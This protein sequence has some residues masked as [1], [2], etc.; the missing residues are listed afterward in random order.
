MAK[1][2]KRAL[3]LVLVIVMVL[4]L[5]ITAFAIDDANK[6]I[7]LSPETT[8][9]YVGGASATL[10]AVVSGYTSGDRI[11]WSSDNTAALSLGSSY[12][13]VNNQGIA[14]CY[15]TPR[16]GI[17]ADTTVTVTAQLNNGKV[18]KATVVVKPDRVSGMAIMQNNT[19]VSG[20]TIDL[21]KGS[22]TQFS[23]AAV[24]ANGSAVTNPGVKW[25]SSSANIANVSGSGYVTGIAPGKTSIQ[26]TSTDG[27]GIYAT[28]IINVVDR[29]ANAA[30][31]ISFPSTDAVFYVMKSTYN[32]SV[33]LTV[34]AASSG[35]ISYQWYQKS[36]TGGVDTPI[37]GARSAT[38]TPSV[39]AVGDTSYYCVV[40]N[41]TATTAS[42]LFTVSVKEPYEV[43][44]TGS[45]SVSIGS[46]VNVTANVY[47][48]TVANYKLTRENITAGQI[49]WTVS[50]TNALSF[51]ANTDTAS[52]TS[53]LNGNTVSVMV[54]GKGATTAAYVSA[55]YSLN[56]STYSTNLP[57]E[58]K[59]TTADVSAVVPMGGKELGMADTNSYTPFSLQSQ[60]ADAAPNID[61]IVFNTAKASSTAACGSFSAKDGNKY[62]ITSGWLSGNHKLSDVKFTS[63]ST[64]G[65][66]TVPYTAYG[67]SGDALCTGNMTI[68][69]YDTSTSTISVFY[70][71][72]INGSIGFSQGD[73][74]AW[75]KAQAGD[76][77]SLTSVKLTTLPGA[78]ELN[79][80][81]TAVDTSTLYYT[82]EQASNL[83]KLINNI[84]YKAPAN[85]GCYPVAFTCTG[86]QSAASPQLSKTGT[87][88]LCVTK[89]TVSDITYGVNSKL[90]QALN[91]VDFSSV[92]TAA[93]G[94]G[95]ASPQL[96]VRFITTPAM[97]ALYRGG[98]TTEANKV[99]AGDYSYYVNRSD[100]SIYNIGNMS[101]VT[102]DKD[103]DKGIDYV[104]YGVYDLSGTLIYVGKVKFDYSTAVGCVDSYPEGHTFTKADFPEITASDPIATLRFA[105]PAS[106]GSL[107]RD[108]KNGTGTLVETTDE[109]Y[110]TTAVKDAYPLT[111]LTFI[112]D[113]GNTENVVF[114]YTAVTNGNK[115]IN[116]SITM[117]AKTRAKSANFT[118]VTAAW[119]IGSVDY[120][121]NWGLVSGTDAVKKTFTPNGT[122]S[123][124]MMVAIL[125]RM[126]GS[127]AYENYS[128]SFTDIDGQGSSWY[129]DAV[130][131][132]YHNGYI[133][134]TGKTTF[135][136]N[137]SITR[138]EIASILWR[139]AGSPEASTSLSGYK[140]A[141]SIASYADTA[142]QWAVANNLI[143]GDNGYLRPAT[144]ASRAQVAAIIHRY[145]A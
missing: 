101:Y 102:S 48:N 59:Y 129:K 106:G 49:S 76:N 5:G 118:D 82:K 12:S 60:L 50:D 2:I 126:A 83:Q 103:K 128:H 56:N 110:T 29:V 63:S 17:T 41:G 84:K 122:M 86:K 104:N 136:P 22:S 131:W 46:G 40:S 61:Y 4:S 26:A 45:D 137:A 111:S 81:V 31:V 99:T 52:I 18:A 69:V 70:N 47:K 32:A 11:T 28:V 138:Q 1:N 117:L 119:A 24:H 57:I 3:S 105:Q 124:A 36:T 143:A 71:T 55:S 115:T 20:L 19:D 94:D 34:Q 10:T 53:T 64:P 23:A 123:R 130:V 91:D 88:F 74:E 140:D 98:Y 9:L 14:T 108:Y 30:P 37:N 43:V 42:K 120:C 21:L 78:G 77:Y 51:N 66:Y 90:V 113:A 35:S 112:P 73:F 127:P 116:D 95:S 6:T 121:A 134:G 93:T 54:Y 145:L 58:V 85:P 79:N 132:A 16:A 7:S 33:P 38:Y 39:S 133:S 135:S 139:Y 27:S 67:S 96:T 15:I 100:D 107:Y 80:G 109:F 87:L 13:Y 72:T 141:K 62:Y 44:L 97:G 125:Y 68:R 75:Y 65:T 142:M 89:G 92:Y 114:R 25:S 144:A 8:T